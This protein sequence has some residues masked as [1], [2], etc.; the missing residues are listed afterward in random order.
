[1]PQLIKNVRN[2]NLITFDTGSFDNW[3]VYLTRAGKE[4]YAPR[5]LEYFTILSNF[6][7]KYGCQKVY[8]DFVRIFN[9][10]H[11][12]ISPEVL[13]LITDIAAGYGVDSEEIDIWFT[14]VYAGMIAEEN[15][16][17]AILGK[18]IKRLGMYQLLIE[19]MSPESAANFSKGKKWKELDA[20]MKEKG[21]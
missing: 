11:K 14:V 3:C 1:M 4:R 5:D 2:K 12:E 6:G 17:N 8:D 18:R 9:K 19:K 21:F 20:I 16:A 10:T 13:Q 7:V 15:K